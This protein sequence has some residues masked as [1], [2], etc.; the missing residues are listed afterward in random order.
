ME[1]LGYLPPKDL[2]NM[3]RVST[4]LAGLA[5]DKKLWRRTFIFDL[6]LYRAEEDFCSRD[7]YNLTGR[8]WPEASILAPLTDLTGDDLA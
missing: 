4:R 1:I 8:F 7:L 2:V 3:R 6:H 5:G